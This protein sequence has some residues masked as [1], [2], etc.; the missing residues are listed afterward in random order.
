M[1][2][3]KRGPSLFEV[4][5]KG[6]PPPDDNRLAVPRWWGSGDTIRPPHADR[7][8]GGAAPVDGREQRPESGLHN[9][10]LVT[11]DGPKLVLSFSSSS[12]GVTAFIL[13]ALIAGAYLIGRASGLSKGR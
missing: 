2:R 9:A 10:P 6:S 3:A 13:F 11:V 12:A 7:T 8:Q 1:P 4:I 5:K